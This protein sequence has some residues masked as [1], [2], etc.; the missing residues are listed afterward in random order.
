VVVDASNGM[1]GRMAPQVFGGVD[2]LTVVPLLF[3]TDGSF[4]HPPNPLVESN[5]RLLK[6]KMERVKPDLGVCFDGDADRCVFLD[7][8]AR[9]IG[10]DL[11]TALLARDYLSVPQNKGATVVYDLRSSHVVPDVVRENGGVPRRERVGHAFIKSTMLQSNAVFGGEVSGHFYFRENFFTDSGAIAL[12]RVASVLSQSSGTFSQL[13]GPFDRYART[14][15]LNFRVEDKEGAMRSL[16][17][18][19]K[20][21]PIDYLDGITVDGGS[22]WFNV[23]KSNTEPFLRLNLEAQDPQILATCLANLKR[24]LGEPIDGH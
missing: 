8:Q 2:G 4:V 9:T 12:A 22:W 23:R 24:I 1:A 15:E 14:G 19:H 16:A 7:E 5:L 6:E 18:N 20:R 11:I 17:E 10:C 3:Q 13:I 21:L